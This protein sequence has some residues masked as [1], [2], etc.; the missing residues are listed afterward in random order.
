MPVIKS[1]KKAQRRDRRRGV[2]N[3]KIRRKMKLAVKLVKKNPSA[4]N[5][6][7]AYRMVD[8]AAKKGV[9]HKNKAARLKS[10]LTQQIK[11]I[12]ASKVSKVKKV[13]KIKK[14]MSPPKKKPVKKKLK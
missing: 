11:G 1:A 7:E 2:V 12:K 6:A 10:R 5:L 3:D 4:K 9:V 13:I 14:A 8:R